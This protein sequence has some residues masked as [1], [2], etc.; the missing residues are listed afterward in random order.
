MAYLKLCQK[1]LLFLYTVL[2]LKLQ[3]R[4]VKFTLF[5]NAK[6]DWDMSISGFPNKFSMLNI[7]KGTKY[8]K[9]KILGPWD[10]FNGH[11]GGLKKKDSDAF[12]VEFIS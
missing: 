5:Q 2:H 6:K 3:D 1:C 12:R 11:L 4:S 10:F 8:F 7:F 9:L